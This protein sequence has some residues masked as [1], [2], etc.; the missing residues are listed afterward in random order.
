VSL[1]F[2]A[3]HS[4]PSCLLRVYGRRA[5]CF[6]ALVGS[7][8]TGAS[9]KAQEQSAR[10]NSPEALSL[11]ARGQAARL[12]E[13][14]Q[15]TLQS[16]E[17]LTE[18]HIYFYVD[19]DDGE[20]ALIRVDQ[21]AVELYWQ[22]PDQIRQ[23]IVGE[24][25]ETRLPVRDF[26]Y[27]LDRLTLVQYGFEDE[28]Q[29]GQG[30][31]VAN[32]P[33]PL[34]PPQ[35]G[36]P[37]RYPYDVQ[38]GE[39]V[40]LRLPGE[41]EPL[42]VREL[43]VR[44]RDASQP[45]FVGSVFLSERD[46]QVVR[47]IFTFTP[48]SYVDRRTDW[49]RVSL[50]YGLWEGRYWLPN[51]QELEVRREVPELDLGIGTVIRAVLRVGNY[52]LNAPIPEGILAAPPVTQF[53]AEMR[54]AF[55]FRDGL[56]QALERD[57][58]ASVQLDV[59]PRRIRQEASRLMASLPPTGL[60]PLRFHLPAFS[61]LI[62]ADPYRGVSLGG[63]ASWRPYGTIRLRARAGTSLN[64]QRPEG[65]LLLDGLNV[66]EQALSLAIQLNEGMDRSARSAGPGLL[67]SVSTL[68]LGESYRSPWRQSG[69]MAT[70]RMAPAQGIVLGVSGGGVR[71]RS[72]TLTWESPPWGAS[73]RLNR[74]PPRILEGTFG[75]VGIHFE[76]V[77][78]SPLRIPGRVTARFES[79][80]LVGREARVARLEAEA[81]WSLQSR[82]Q[83][84]DVRVLVQ[85]GT[86]GGDALTQFHQTLGGAGTLPGLPFAERVSPHWGLTSVE[87][88]RE[89]GT[90][91]VRLRG[92]LDSGWADDGLGTS[93]GVRAGVG[94]VYDILRIEGARIVSGYGT[95]HGW[96][97][98]V[99][100]HPMWWPY[101]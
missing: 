98:I 66:R 82:D 93:I 86:M 10:W 47:M 62:R 23:R 14:D 45:G 22:A 65:S 18:G 49:I 100:I 92:A 91:W 35:G 29:V 1:L 39:A 94:L 31:D 70:T 40:T 15:G 28:I 7:S 90:P 55:P 74:G 13:V 59:D 27:Y 69:I 37:S 11:L 72:E 17:A 24:R 83:R 12:Q 4:T 52:E 84:G 20:Q 71:H 97:L 9:L 88:S 87:G 68:T 19:T 89:L 58:V 57:G 41:L 26:R 73:G 48:A 81:G 46:A 85:G 76:A 8:L 78:A 96:R 79:E 80:T 77:L 6:L 44:P 61:S 16:Y 60:S 33:H 99:G 53:P 30:M 95:H 25:S 56:Y 64:T 38:L 67:T 32:V 50:D 75:K 3:V 51:R 42:A 63:G 54:S 34:A 2:I 5:I 101:L 21:V 36:D 43:R